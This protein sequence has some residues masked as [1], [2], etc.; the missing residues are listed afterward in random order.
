[1]TDVTSFETDP[2]KL[3]NEAKGW[4][5]A[6]WKCAKITTGKDDRAMHTAARWANVSPN[7]LWKLR[8]RPPR[9][10]DVSIYNRLKVAYVERVESVEGQIAENFEALKALPPTPSRQRLVAAMEEFLGAAPGAEDDDLAS[11]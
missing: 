11:R 7:T 3:L 1:M 4:A 5:K 10:I 8:Y 9:G 6:L 2:D